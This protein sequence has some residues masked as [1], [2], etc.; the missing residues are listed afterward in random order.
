M[1]F[2]AMATWQALLV[3]A[4]VIAGAVY[5]F[6]MKIRPPQIRVP[7]LTLWTRVLDEVREQS[8]WERYR[9]AISLIVAVLITLALLIAVLRPQRAV[10]DARAGSSAVVGGR[11]S[12]VIDSS[13]S[14]LA[15][16]SNGQTRWDRAVSR[17]RALA[18][19]AAGED[20]VLSTTADGVIEGP[21]PD[22]ALIEAAL[23]R[24]APS[25]GDAT[26]FPRVEGARQTHFLTDGAVP[27]ALE[28]D[29]LVESV[30]EPADNVAITAFDVRPASA[31]DSAGQAFL[32]V[33]NYSKTPQDVHITLVRGNASL[34]D[35]HSELAAGAA[36]Q[37]MVPLDR[38]GDA[39]IR[40][41]VSAKANALVVD[42]EAVAVIDGVQPINVVVVSDQ[43]ATFG[44][45]ITQTPGVTATFVRPVNYKPGNEN[46]V[47]FDRALPSAAPTA[48]ALYI[49]PPAAPPLKETTPSV[50]SPKAT[51]EVGASRAEEHPQ[52]V[53][54]GWHPIMQGVDV[55]TMALDRARPYVAD[56]LEAVSVSST[57]MPLVYVRDTPQQRFAL[58]TFGVTESKLMF[59]PGFPVLIG[60]AVDWL[61]HAAPTGVRH[62]GRVTFPGTIVSL[63]GPDGK[64]VPM[65]VVD[66]ATIATLATPGFYQ[67]TSAGASR[68]IAVNAGDPDTS[69][70]QRTRLPQAAANSADSSAGRGRPWWLLAGML[71]FLL[72]AAEWWTWQRR[73]TV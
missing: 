71:A 20:V 69:D 31:T 52:W 27:R 4:A 7:S 26:A 25:G 38:V 62:P 33:A 40:A 36:V 39:R 49:A 9:K 37:R 5:L 48:P 64:E 46:L 13:W 59:A 23:D 44:P 29:V 24:I 60:N 50:A 11:T 43:A 72:L 53:S 14:M 68:V 19:A 51:P 70:L 6:L 15:E 45:I 42:D 56:G 55:Q 73:V 34:L 65:T 67:A 54:G 17:A 32:E 47:I 57:N 3:M 22:V 10:V 61:T 2:A 41:R 21:T 35:V 63:V 30:F 66:D 16:T 12:I 8:W 28:A 58:F 1:S 18:L